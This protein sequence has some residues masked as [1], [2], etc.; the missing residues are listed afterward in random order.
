MIQ[1]YD[2]TAWGTDAGDYGIDF[3]EWDHG[4]W[5]KWEDVKEILDKLE[6]LANN[7]FLASDANVCEIAKII[8]REWNP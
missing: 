2:I 6:G 7:P 3:D 1:R 5:V 8:G 4:D